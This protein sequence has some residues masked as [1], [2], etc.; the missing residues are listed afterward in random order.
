LRGDTAGAFMPR[1]MEAC[2]S[3]G[4]NE[5]AGRPNAP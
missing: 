3:R 4:K 1:I 5:R 2:T